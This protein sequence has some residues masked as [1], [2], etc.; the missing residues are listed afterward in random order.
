VQGLVI[1]AP[2]GIAIR[3]AV[4]MVHAAG[5]ATRSGAAINSHIQAAVQLVFEQFLLGSR[6]FRE[7]LHVVI[8]YDAIGDISLM[9]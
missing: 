4:V 1:L 6:V 3:R 2:S 9:V 7:Y 8:V 5:R